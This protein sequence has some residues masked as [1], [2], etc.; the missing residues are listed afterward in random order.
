MNE[1][2]HLQ[3]IN[4]EVKKGEFVCIIGKVAS[5]KSNLLNAINGEMIYCPD[6]DLEGKKN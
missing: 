3:D 6:E 2:L 5:G 4:L 1:K